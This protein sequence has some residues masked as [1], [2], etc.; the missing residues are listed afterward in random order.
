MA[1]ILIIEDETVVAQSI[2]FFL[3]ASEH[4]LVGITDSGIEAIHQ[5][6]DLN[7]DLILMDIYL[8]GEIDGITAAEQIYQQWG[9]PI[10]YLS[11]TTEDTTLK[12]AIASQP[13][14]YLVKPFDQTQLLLSLIHI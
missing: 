13:F 8:R 5:A 10:I 6:Q 4:Q 2:Q 1:R 14:G 11:G 3:A 7:P 12:R 9:I